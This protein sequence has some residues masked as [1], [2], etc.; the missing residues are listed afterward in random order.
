MANRIA[1]ISVVT[2]LFFASAVL[3]VSA[4][5]PTRE[6][7]QQAQSREP[8]AKSPEQCPKADASVKSQRAYHK[9][10]PTG[11]LPATLDPAQF[12]SNKAAFVSY[13]IAAK[14]AKLLYQEPCYCPCDKFQGHKSLLDCFTSDHGKFCDVCDAE[15]IFVYEQSKRGKTAAEIR[16]AM[17]K[18]NAWKVDPANYVQAHYSE[19][20]QASPL[21][22]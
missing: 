2:P 7:S 5:N 10:P 15:L 8:Q 20:T 12:P 18:D 13:S 6:P 19:Y 4:G 14:V 22:E 17:E 16:D 11:P 3:A 1:G 21:N 9:E